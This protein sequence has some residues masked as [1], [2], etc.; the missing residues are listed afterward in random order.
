MTQ[1][2]QLPTLLRKIPD[3]R[4]PVRVVG[5]AATNPKALVRF[6]AC[7]AP[8]VCRGADSSPGCKCK[9]HHMDTLEATC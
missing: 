8:E 2:T 4:Q 9:A 1:D 3:M 5:I 6:C 7:T